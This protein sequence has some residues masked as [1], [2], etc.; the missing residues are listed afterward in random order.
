MS[1]VDTL[2]RAVHHLNRVVKFMRDNPEA[3]AKLV[4]PI[5]VVAVDASTQPQTIPSSEFPNVKFCCVNEFSVSAFSG[6]AIAGIFSLLALPEE[7]LRRIKTS[8]LSLKCEGVPV[9]TDVPNA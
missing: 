6:V 3:A 4:T 8:Q 5:L 1:G 2:N 7:G 9:V